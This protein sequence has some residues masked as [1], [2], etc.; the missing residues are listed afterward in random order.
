MLDNDEPIEYKLT[1]EQLQFANKL[2]RTTDNYRRNA[3]NFLKK[4]SLSGEKSIRILKNL[5]QDKSIVIT[6][7]DK[8]RCVVVSDRSE[9]IKQ[10]ESL[11]NNRTTF[12]LFDT[13]PTI[14]QEDRLVRKLRKLKAD[15]CISEAEYNYC[16]PTGSQPAR[17]YGLPKVHKDNLSFRPL[18]AASGTFNYKLAKRLC[19]RLAH[20]RESETIIKDTFS[21]V[22]QLHSLELNMTKHKL[23]SFDITSLFTNI[24]LTETIQ[25]ILNKLYTEPCICIPPEKP[26]HDIF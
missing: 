12:K 21:F 17:L 5:G 2:R 11:I 26:I 4:H 24:L 9:Y 23:V 6:K 18:L 15:K 8:G 10:M 22:D 20:L 16:F 1:P 3:L 7:A 25:I 14:A 13:D 19:K